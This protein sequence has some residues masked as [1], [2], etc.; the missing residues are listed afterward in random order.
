MLTPGDI[1]TA[2]DSGKKF[3]VSMAGGKSYDVPHT[4][5]VAFTRTRGSIV[6]FDENSRQHILPLATMTAI[7]YLEPTDDPIEH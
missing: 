4:D 3:Q 7:S 6:F 5:F 2:L 1:R